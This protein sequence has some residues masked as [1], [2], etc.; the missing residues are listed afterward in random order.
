MVVLLPIS[1]T[2]FLTIGRPLA[3]SE[4]DV[5]SA[6]VSV[7]VQFEASTMVEGLPRLAAM[8]AAFRPA[9]SPQAMF[10][11]PRA[12]AASAAVAA[13]VTA[14]SP[15]AS[16]DHSPKNAFTHAFPVT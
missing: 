7:Y 6:A 2:V 5:L 14:I 12:G 13:A 4:R 10:T 16:A 11:V 3:P 1:V 15:D 9:T 8:M